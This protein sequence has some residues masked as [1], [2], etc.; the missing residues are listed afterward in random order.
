MTR[1][2]LHGTSAIKIGRIVG[3][4]VEAT[5]RGILQARIALLAR[6]PDEAEKLLE[7]VDERLGFIGCVQEHLRNGEADAAFDVAATRGDERWGMM[8]TARGALKGNRRDSNG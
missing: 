3:L 4:E 2:T 7:T 8:L 6:R 5:R 1:K